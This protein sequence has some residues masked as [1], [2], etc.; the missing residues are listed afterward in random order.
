MV[1]GRVVAREGRLTT[2]DEA[3]I[4]AEAS[5]FFAGKK[6]AID[7]ADRAI[8]K[9]LPHYHEMYRRAGSYDLPFERRIP[10]PV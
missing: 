2:I 6:Q 3:A 9:F 7:I 4:L 1:G 5:A 10:N 8:E